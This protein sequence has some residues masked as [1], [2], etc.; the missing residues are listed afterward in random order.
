MG[1]EKLENQKIEEKD[2]DNVAG[3]YDVKINYCTPSNTEPPKTQGTLFVDDKELKILKDAKL[4][5]ENG[6]I[7]EENLGVAQLA[8]GFLPDSETGKKRGKNEIIID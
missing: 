7:D 1:N 3:G 5:N 8:L 4:L 2:L 6:H